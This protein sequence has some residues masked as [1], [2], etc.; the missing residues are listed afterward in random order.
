MPLSN[1]TNPGSAGRSD[2]RH[3]WQ[4]LLV[5][6]TPMT[7][8]LSAIGTKTYLYNAHPPSDFYYPIISLLLLSATPTIPWFFHHLDSSQSTSM[9]LLQHLQSGTAITVS[10]GSYFEDFDIGACGWIVATP[11]DAEAW[12]EGGGLIP[13]AASDRNV[14]HR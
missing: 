2:E 7:L 9:R 1:N 12:I 10:D 5:P 4:E 11:P 8:E 3:S 6:S 14:D 13:S